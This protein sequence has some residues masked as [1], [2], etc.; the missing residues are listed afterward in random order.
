MSKHHLALAAC[1]ATSLA[2]APPALAQA[3][4]ATPGLQAV[5]ECRAV[6]DSAARLA[7]FER[8]VSTLQAALAAREVV[9]VDREQARAARR[10]AFGFSIPS[11]NIFDRVLG[12]SEASEMTFKVARASL[13][14]E[15]YWTIETEDG[16]V[17]R[18][19]ESGPRVRPRKGSTV[20]IRRGTLGL[21][22]MNVDGSRA[23]SVTRV[24]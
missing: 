4:Q 16:L 22:R 13:G 9:V 15:G 10:E 1:A 3:V 8:T 12:A 14:S 18:Q 20:E 17:W 23:I 2:I 11:L 24:R 19:T 5:F 21:Y 6:A 7:C